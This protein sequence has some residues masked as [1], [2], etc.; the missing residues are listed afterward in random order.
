MGENKY[1]KIFSIVFFVAFAAVSCWATAESLHLLLP[2]WPSFACWAV[3]IGFFIIASI[4]SKLLVDSLNQNIYVEKRGLKLVGG[5]FLLLVFWLVCSMPT[6]TH[7]FFYRTCIL[8]VTLDDLKN[9]EGYLTE[10][11]D[12]TFAEEKF[13]LQCADLEGKVNAKLEDLRL[14][15][16][17]PDHGD[18]PKAQSILVEISELLKCAHINKIDGPTATKQQRTKLVNAYRDKVLQQL[19]VR[20]AA[21]YLQLVDKKKVEQ[22]KKDAEI[23][24]KKVQNAIS[25]IS[26]MK[27]NGDLDE[28]TINISNTVLKN[29]YS[30][31]KNYSNMVT[32]KSDNDKELYTANN[33]VTKTTKLLSVVDTWKDFIKG[34]YKG[35]GFIFWIIISILVDIAAFIFFTI[36][37]KEEEN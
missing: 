18:G 19:K 12:N 25:G 31:I 28:P 37:V 29:A 9:T 2:T 23:D 26:E 35:R 34:E 1:I 24:I 21:I 11:R 32:F 36:A 17:G 22:A 15:I 5:C 4:G 20:E 30:T 13:R 8:D 16:E 27:S 7:T 3:T 10:I 14:E 6:N 33:Q